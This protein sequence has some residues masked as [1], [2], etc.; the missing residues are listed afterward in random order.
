MILSNN[1]SGINIKLEKN[2]DLIVQGI[3]G[4]QGRF[5]TKMMLDFGMNIIAGATPGKAGETVENV[6][7]FNGI[8]DIEKKI[9]V[10]PGATAVFVPAAG[11]KDAILEA[12]FYEIPLIVCITEG[13]PVHDT[14]LIN[15]YIAAK[16]NKSVL[17]GPNCPGIIVPEECDISIHLP[18]WYHKGEAAI[19][20]RSGSLSYEAAS[21]LWDAGIGISLIWGIGGDPVPGMTFVDI[22]ELLREN[23]DTRGIIILGEIGGEMEQKAADYI[24]ETKYPKPVMLYIAG[25]YAPK[26]KRMGHAGAL[27]SGSGE[28]ALVKLEYWQKRGLKTCSNIL[29]I[30]EAGKELFGL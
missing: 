17:I 14:C 24:I 20:S 8:G 2:I 10:K 18:D 9:G 27:I 7:V 26:N 5:F 11:A 6:P 22:L 19:I 30:K 28:T 29:K 21:R 23:Q 12:V 1:K 15:S 16:N 25:V 4:K 3:T 13:V